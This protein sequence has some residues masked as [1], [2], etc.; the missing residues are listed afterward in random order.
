[1]IKFI[2]KGKFLIIIVLINL[3][4]SFFFLN[5]IKAE[6]P[7]GDYGLTEAK[8]AELPKYVEPAEKVGQIVGYLLSFVGLLF[9]ILVIYGGYTWMTAGGNEQEVSKAKSLLTQ[10]VFGL[11]IVASAYLLVKFVGDIVLG[12]FTT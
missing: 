7:M 9:L 8:P 6:G 3:F 4:V 12:Q 1:M 5:I 11:I 2:N 10:A